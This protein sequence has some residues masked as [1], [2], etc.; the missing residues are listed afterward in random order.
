MN[1]TRRLHCLLLGSAVVAALSCEQPVRPVA[2]LLDPPLHLPSLLSCAPQPYD[3]VTQAIGPAGGSIQV[4]GNL[5]QVPAGALVSTVA[6]T[7]VAPSDTVNQVRFQPTGLDFAV[8]ATLTM[9]YANCSLLGVLLPKRIAY[10]TDNLIILQLLP[11]VDDALNQTLTTRLG[12]FST[13]AVA[14]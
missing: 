6:I 11:S 12:H 8:P 4:A 13:Y 14:W 9:N 10:T 7:A 3:S 5:L 1:A 2:S